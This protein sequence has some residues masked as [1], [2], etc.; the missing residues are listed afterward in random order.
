MFHST[1]FNGFSSD[2][3]EEN[4]LCSNCV[5]LHLIPPPAIYQSNVELVGGVHA[6]LNMHHGS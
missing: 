5:D 3:L 2:T 4:S 1:K 6:A